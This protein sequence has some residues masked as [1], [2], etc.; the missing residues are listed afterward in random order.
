LE[1]AFP[2]AAVKA[3]TRNALIPKNEYK[4]LKFIAAGNATRY[5]FQYL[6]NSEAEK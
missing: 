6:R 2:L 4:A 5:E 3:L 1:L